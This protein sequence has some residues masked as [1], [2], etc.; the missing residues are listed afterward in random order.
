M[1]SETQTQLQSQSQHPDEP[2]SNDTPSQEQDQQPKSNRRWLIVGGIAIAVI[3][4][5]IA[6]L[7]LESGDGT[8]ALTGRSISPMMAVFAFL[9]GLLS[10]LSPCTLPILPAYFAF[11][12]QSQRGNIVVMTVSF[13]LGLATTMTVLGASLTALGTLVSGNR[14][15]LMFWGGIIVIVFGVM[16]LLGKGFAGPQLKSRPVASG[17]G[18]YLYGAT[19]ALGWTACIGP[20]LGALYT[21]LAAQGVAVLQGAVL[22]FV[23]ALGLGMPLIIMA[24]FFS[25]LGSGSAFWKIVRGKGFEVK[26]GP[27]NLY[28]HTTSIVSGILLI[29]MGILLANGNLT[30]ITSVAQD[31]PIVQWFDKL[32]FELALRFNL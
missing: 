16:S 4:F 28:L 17:F 5:I 31:N 2:T 27:W 22:S 23:Y 29:V 6:I 26:V 13:F 12:F 32:Y 11:T 25:R 21:M 9:A 30:K 3:L 19:F 14:H 18:S 15:T 8:A 1:S 20:I 7:S 10:F 24:T